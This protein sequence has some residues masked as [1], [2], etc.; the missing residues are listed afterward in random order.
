V[1]TF[2]PSTIPRNAMQKL[3][4]ILRCE[5]WRFLC[6]W[7]ETQKQRVC[8]L[9]P[10]TTYTNTN[11]LVFEI[12]QTSYHH[13]HSIPRP[14][15]LHRNPTAQPSPLTKCIHTMPAGGQTAL[16]RAARGS[17]E[18]YHTIQIRSRQGSRLQAS[19]KTQ[20]AH[21]SDHQTSS[22]RPQS[23]HDF[24]SCDEHCLASSWVFVVF[25]C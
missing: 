17:M 2:P 10:T 5:K 9:P 4:R 3:T 23:R 20:H 8:L 16:N 7:E 12:R 24:G 19:R 13:H 6:F 11:T 18:I 15:Q 1:V 22:Q 14:N 25:G 21:Q